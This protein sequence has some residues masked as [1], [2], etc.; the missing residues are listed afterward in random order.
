MTTAFWL[1]GLALAVYV[2]FFL[3]NE[4]RQAFD[5][6]FRMMRFGAAFPILFV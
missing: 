1:G 2:G 6:A 5:I 4:K 3:Q